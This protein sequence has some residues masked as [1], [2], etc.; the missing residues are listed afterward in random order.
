MAMTRRFTPD[1]V[2]EIR[3]QALLGIKSIQ[4]IANDNKVGRSSI[5]AIVD[6][7]TYKE[8]EYFG[9]TQRPQSGRPTP[10]AFKRMVKEDR[11]SGFSVRQ[12]ADRHLVSE[13]T[14]RRILK[15]TKS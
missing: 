5:R 8:C 1:Q 10:E 9:R 7:L 4:Q 12:I 13:P 15:G 6:G 3:S 14:I 2:I 11:R